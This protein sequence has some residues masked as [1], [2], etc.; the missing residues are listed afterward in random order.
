MNDNYLQLKNNVLSK[1]HF[2]AEIII[3]YI[4][5]LED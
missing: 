4:P 5:N 3:E 2:I 1:N